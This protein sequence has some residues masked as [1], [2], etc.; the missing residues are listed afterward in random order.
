M[1]PQKKSYEFVEIESRP[2]F[3]RELDFDG[4]SPKEMRERC[5]REIEDACKSTRT[6]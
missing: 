6:R 4:G 3:V 5:E 1:T 2:F